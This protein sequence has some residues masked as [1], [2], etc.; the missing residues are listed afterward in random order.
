[1]CFCSN[2]FCTTPVCLCNQ[3][4]ELLPRKPINPR[5][6]VCEKCRYLT[7]KIPYKITSN[8]NPDWTY[9]WHLQV[10]ANQA[11]AVLTFQLNYFAT[12][13]WIRKFLK[14]KLYRSNTQKSL[15]LL[16]TAKIR[17][18]ELYPTINPLLFLLSLQPKNPLSLRSMLANG[19]IIVLHRINWYKLLLSMDRLIIN[20][21]PNYN[22]SYLMLRSFFPKPVITVS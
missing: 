11:I 8:S 15:M 1:M 13:D 5:P 10:H 12:V 7:P 18:I 20:K 16:I 14:K 9:L 3:S 22:S 21:G 6:L 4:K 2:L 17:T 19:M